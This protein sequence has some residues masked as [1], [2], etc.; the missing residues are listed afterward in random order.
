MK[1]EIIFPQYPYISAE[2]KKIIKRMLV[3]EEK[4]RIDWEFLFN[5]YLFK[6]PA[7]HPQPPQANFYTVDINMQG[8]FRESYFIESHQHLRKILRSVNL[9]S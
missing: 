3:I 5:E 7:P 9:C 1:K 6:P 2:T 8:Y 4:D